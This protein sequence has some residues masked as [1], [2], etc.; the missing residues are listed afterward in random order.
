MKSIEEMRGFGR[1][2]I[3]PICSFILGRDSVECILIDRLIDYVASDIASGDDILGIIGAH[4]CIYLLFD[5]GILSDFETRI[6]PGHG[7]GLSD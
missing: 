6:Y 5:I 3:I 1:R 4:Y 7:P 2:D